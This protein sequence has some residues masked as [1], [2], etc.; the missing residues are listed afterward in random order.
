MARPTKF[1]ADMPE[2]AEKLCWKLGADIGDV[3]SALGVSVSCVEKWMQTR[4]EFRAAVQRCR[5]DFDSGQVAIA[6]KRRALG[7]ETVE[8][9]LEASGELD[10]ETGQ[11]ILMCTKE[12]HKHVPPETA[13]CCFWLKNRQ[14]GR[15]KDKQQIEHSVDED[16]SKLLREAEE[17]ATRRS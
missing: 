8:R 3:A 17:R 10:P 11:P 7:Y 15:W 4:P 2:R 13:A 6:L 14:P 16:L 9:T 1:E 12:V 5:D